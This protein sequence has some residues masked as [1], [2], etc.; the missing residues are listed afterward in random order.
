MPLRN[1]NGRSIP[2]W[3]SLLI[4]FATVPPI[5]RAAAFQPWPQSIQHDRLSY[6]KTMGRSSCLKVIKDETGTLSSDNNSGGAT[7]STYH[8][9]SIEYCT[10][11][12][13]MLKSFWLAQELLSTFGK[14]ELDAVTV[15]PSFDT[16]GKFVICM[17]EMKQKDVVGDPILLWNRTKQDGFPGPKELKQ[18]VR[19]VINPDLYLGHSDTE[20]RQREHES[21][22]MEQ[23]ST[24]DVPTTTIFSKQVPLNPYFTP[25]PS[26][27]IHYCTGCQWLLRAAYFGQEL[28]TTFGG[29]ELKSV[30][31]V[32]SKPPEKGGRFSIE[33]DG[34]VLFDRKTEGRFPEP[35]EIKQMI[36]DR[37]APSKDLGHSDVEGKQSRSGMEVD[38]EGMDEDEAEEARKY[39]GVL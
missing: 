3:Q 15:I 37:I 32:P 33:L 7:K 22:T 17:S 2:L 12:R 19:D 31:L 25:S 28:L 23:S 30:T 36:R 6:K 10:G 39:F 26:V 18:L 21:G 38:I 9:V 27:T 5:K 11:C 4:F 14:D 34:E 24:S 16:K 1:C 13:W 8:H 20:I 35:K 29:G